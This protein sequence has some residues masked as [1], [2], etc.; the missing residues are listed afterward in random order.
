MALTSALILR[1]YYL[2]LETIVETNALDRVIA[3]IFL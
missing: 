3:G 2:E 1:H